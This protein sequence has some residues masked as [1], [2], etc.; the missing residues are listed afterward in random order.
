V[1]RTAASHQSHQKRP[2]APPDI[3]NYL[4]LS[5]VR[6]PHTSQVNKSKGLALLEDH[7][8]TPIS[9]FDLDI[10]AP[11]DNKIVLTILRLHKTMAHGVSDYEDS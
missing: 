7:K 10:L 8:K 3:E 5:V 4:M 6:I 9:A 2:H 1:K 11:K